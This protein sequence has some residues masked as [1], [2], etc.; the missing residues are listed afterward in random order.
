MRTK[1]EPLIALGRNLAANM[2]GSSRSGATN[3][4]QGSKSTSG[5]R[6]HYQAGDQVLLMSKEDG[7]WYRV[8]VEDVKTA[9]EVVVSFGSKEMGYETVPAPDVDKRLRQRTIHL[10]GLPP[11]WSGLDTQCMPTCRLHF[12]H[13][14]PW[15][16]KFLTWV[17][18][19]GDTFSAFQMV[20]AITLP[21]ICT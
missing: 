16:K 14:L 2:P 9:G 7:M 21:A 18:M 8:V 19:Q 10:E 11:G 6:V 15:M 12:Y 13:T 1:S 5:F 4:S 3:S 17:H 20:P